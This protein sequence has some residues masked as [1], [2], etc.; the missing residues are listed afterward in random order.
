[1]SRPARTPWTGEQDPELGPTIACCGCH[2]GRGGGLAAND[3]EAECWWGG[4]GGGGANSR[5]AH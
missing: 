4:G 2:V 5:N 3:G 1:M